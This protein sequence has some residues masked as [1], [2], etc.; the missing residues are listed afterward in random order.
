LKGWLQKGLAGL[1]SGDG[2]SG[3]STIALQVLIAITAG[4]EEVYGIEIPENMRRRPVFMLNFED[5]KKTMH[6]RQAAI[7]ELHTI[8]EPARLR[9]LH[10]IHRPGDDGAEEDLPETPPDLAFWRPNRYGQLEATHIWR[11]VV[12]KI[13]DI[14]PA[15]A[16][17]D[18]RAI[19]FEGDDFSR[20]HSRD[21]MHKQLGWLCIRARTTIGLMDHPSISA[22]E[23]GAGTFGTGAWTNSGRWTWLLNRVK[24]QKKG[25]KVPVELDKD[26]RILSKPKIN[27]GNTSD[28]IHLR[29]KPYG[30]TGL[31]VPDGATK[32]KLSA[33][34]RK[35]RARTLFIPML[36]ELKE[37]GRYLSDNTRSGDEKYAPTQ[38]ARRAVMVKGEP[39]G[40]EAFKAAMDA[41]LEEQKIV[42]GEFKRSR[43]LMVTPKGEKERS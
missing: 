13:C 38:L 27:E 4:L 41:L 11:E 20:V 15:L 21:V 18:N 28:E 24:S 8:T 32:S 16:F 3:K 33:G 17:I 1:F 42:V 25:S 7:E 30:R 37:Q 36:L 14:K 22:L 12:E 31:F 2:G 10:V 43:A 39:L 23:R 40:E 26:I 35:A 9:H 19:V 5:S 6:R 29:W 34:E